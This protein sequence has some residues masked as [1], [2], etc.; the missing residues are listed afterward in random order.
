MYELLTSNIIKDCKVRE[1][2]GY[3]NMGTPANTLGWDYQNAS[4]E[5]ETDYANDLKNSK[6]IIVSRSIRQYALRKYSEASIAGALIM[7]NIPPE[8]QNEYRQYMVEI[9]EEEDVESIYQ[10]ILWWLEHEEERLHRARI[11]Q[12]ISMTKYTQDNF[13]DGLVSAWDAYLSGVR[14]GWFPYQFGISGAINL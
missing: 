9:N 14:G 7:G 5:Q 2:P 12:K 6:I 13:V 4:V 11:G 10:K 1:H 3:H 8:R